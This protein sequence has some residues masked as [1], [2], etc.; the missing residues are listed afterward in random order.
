MSYFLLPKIPYDS[1]LLKNIEVT[2]SPDMQGTPLINKTLCNY[3]NNIKGEIDSRQSDWD[4][5]KKYTNP[6]EYIHTAVPNSKQAVCKLKPLSRSFYKMVEMCGLMSLAD[7]LPK[8]CKTFHL[9]EGPGGFIEALCDMRQNTEDRY[10]GMTLIKDEDQSVPGWRKTRSFLNKNPNVSLEYGED[11][12]GDLTKASNLRHCFIEYHGTMDLVTADGGFD[13]SIDFNHQETVSA[14]LIFCQIAFALAVQAKGGNF[15]V[16]FFDAFTKTSIDM[17]YI[18][19]VLYEEVY[20]VKPNTSRYANSEK[21]AVCKKFKM[22]NSEDLVRGLYKIFT[23]FPADQHIEGLL[24]CEVP[25]LYRSK[26][27]E[28]NAIFGQQQI[29]SIASTLNLIDNNKFDRLESIKKN[30]T[31]KCVNW[32]QK[33]RLPFNKVIVATNIFLSGRGS[34]AS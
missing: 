18:L 6:Y 12:T 10:Y 5:F 20:L 9:A 4:K 28:Y 17:L 32:C 11:D 22:D 1:D 31:Q 30:H 34:H 8:D 21:Y 27:E 15:V 29:E 25:Y 33:Y 13:F 16:K 2:Y 14:K 24:T 19:S 26:L 3:L 7:D 23:S